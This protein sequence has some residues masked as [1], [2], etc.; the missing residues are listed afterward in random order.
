MASWRQYTFGVRRGVDERR[1]AVIKT[2]LKRLVEL[3][4]GLDVVRQH[5]KRISTIGYI[6][7]RRRIF[8]EFSID[9][10]LDVGAN[11]GQFGKELRSFY[12]GEIISFEPVSAAFDRLAKTSFND[13]HWR[14]YKV[15]L[16]S[17]DTMKRINVSSRSDFSS[18]L[19]TN[20]Y[21][22]H[23]FG[24]G[25]TGMKEEVVTVRR[26]DGTLEEIIPSISNRSI[27]LKMDTQGFDLEVFK[28]LGDKLK[29]VAVLQSEV[30]V[31]PIYEGMSHWIDCISFYE[32]EGFEVAGLFPVTLDSC[33]VMEFDCLMVRTPGHTRA[34]EV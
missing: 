21:C 23:F 30:S 32:R 4:A 22:T 11:V 10:V 7:Q 29:Y 5:S 28:G 12:K 3:I 33:R 18:F 20:E 27:F 17:Q 8:E 6:L 16:G 13:P 26:L 1:T 31:I 24:D 9:L 34:L 2:C 14:C 19:K 15:A 25:A